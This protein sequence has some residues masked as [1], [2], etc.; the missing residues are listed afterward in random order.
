MNLSLFL[1]AAA[2]VKATIK[3][4]PADAPAEAEG[5]TLWRYKLLDH[6][7]EGRCGVVYVAE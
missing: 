7:G 3:L 1:L 6:V 2:T 4:D 5:Q